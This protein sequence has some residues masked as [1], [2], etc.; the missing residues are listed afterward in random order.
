M[1][2]EIGTLK[3]FIQGRGIYNDFLNYVKESKGETMIPENESQ[4]DKDETLSD[5][6]SEEKEENRKEEVIQSLKD[7]IKELL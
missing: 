2:T 1:R 5:K 4:F 3:N 6:E 7:T